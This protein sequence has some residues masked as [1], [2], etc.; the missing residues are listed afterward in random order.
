MKSPKRPAV[1][2]PP[3]KAEPRAD[4]AAAIAMLER[5]LAREPNKSLREGYRSAVDRLSALS[6]WLRQAAPAEPAAPPAEPPA[7]VAAPE[8]AAPASKVER[9]R[10]TPARG[11]A[12]TIIYGRDISRR[13]LAITKTAARCRIDEGADEADAEGTLAVLEVIG[14][15]EAQYGEVR[16]P[17]GSKSQPTRDLAS[18]TGIGNSAKN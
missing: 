15:Y 13:R 5:H 16:V 10:S 1:I 4:I 8:P 12:G 18:V 6:Y 7:L 17:G 3:S 11:T 2:Y 14:A 9:S